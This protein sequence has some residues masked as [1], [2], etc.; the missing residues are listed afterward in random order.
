M[1]TLFYILVLLLALYGFFSNFSGGTAFVRIFLTVITKVG[2]FYVLLYAG[3]QLF[4]MW[5]VI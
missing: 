4:K 5:G 2:S 1:E 3:V